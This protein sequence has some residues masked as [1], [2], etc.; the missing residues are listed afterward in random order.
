V[1]AGGYKFIDSVMGISFASPAEMSYNAK[2]SSD[3]DDSWHVS[4]FTGTDVATG[5]IVILFSKDVKPGHYITSDTLVYSQLAEYLKTQYSNVRKQDINIQGYA[6]V[7]LSGRSL[8]QPDYYADALSVVKNNRNI[9]L[10]VISDSMHL[11]LSETQK[12]FGSLRFISSPAVNWSLHTTADSLLSARV[13]GAFRTI[14]NGTRRFWCSFD[15]TTA[16]S[17][18]ILPDT[19]SKYAWY[20]HDTSFW[21]ERID[22]YS[23]GFTLEKESDIQFNGTQGKELLIKKDIVYKRMR[24]VLHENKMY[25]VMVSGNKQFVYNDDATAFLNSF[26]I[27]VPAKYTNFINQSKTTLLLNDLN[28][29]DSAIRMEAY[30]SLLSAPFEKSDLPLLHEALLKQYISPFTREQ[31]DAIN[32]RIAVVL[33]ELNDASTISFIK[34]KYPLLEDKQKLKNILL[35][36]L[37]RMHTKE[38][39]AT[40]AQ[41]LDQYGASAQTMNYSCLSAFKDSLA[42]TA[43]IINSLQKLAKDSVHTSFVAQVLVALTDSGFIKQ[44]QLAAA[45]NDYIQTAEKILPSVKGLD[46]YNYGI[47]HI[48]KLLGRCN[49]IEAN[50][51]LKSYL[52]VKNKYLKKAVVMEL[53]KNN[54]S[55]PSQVLTAL[56]A[57]KDIRVELYNDLK[58]QKRTALFPKQYLT[59]ASFAESAIYQ[60]ASD[61]QEPEKISFLWSI[62]RPYNG[63]EYVFYLYRVVFDAEDAYLGIAGGYKPGKKSLEPEKDLTGIYWEKNFA[64][65]KI[66]TFFLDYL[67]SLQSE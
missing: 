52:G 20:K 60:N 23:N 2:I 47:F 53:V 11:Q 43:G 57:E 24:L 37:A 36:V 27:N 4:G 32:Q 44:E 22:Y 58:E 62:T 42:L 33:N 15:T 6:G 34:E 56:A 9:V 19:L 40:L 55:V 29:K 14:D 46:D 26:T 1:S 17:Y 64:V 30:K 66:N 63:K 31:A 28:D 21:K 50:A 39:Y 41:L 3:K 35:G 38:T 5:S 13:P 51:V 25:E 18:L 65:A 16:S 49:T 8:A 12:I 54:Q 48:V 67:I 10:L 59:Q 61:E 45:Q 7:R